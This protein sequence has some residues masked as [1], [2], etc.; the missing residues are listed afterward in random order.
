MER[1]LEMW[2]VLPQGENF[3][4][5]HAARELP[6]EDCQVLDFRKKIRFLREL[7]QND[8]EN[9]IVNLSLARNMR[10]FRKNLKHENFPEKLI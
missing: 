9:A 5:S 7:D 10:S 8:T 4:S 3:R 1:A 2:V 6:R